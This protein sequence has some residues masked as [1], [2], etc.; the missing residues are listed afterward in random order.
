MTGMLLQAI[1]KV[2]LGVLLLAIALP[3]P[4]VSGNCRCADVKKDEGTHW[5]GNESIVMVE[6]TAFRH[7]RGRVEALGNQPVSNALVEIFDH[8]EYLLD[9]STPYRRDHS[10]QKRVAAC[11]TSAD[12][13]FCFRNLP[14]GKYELR[15][16]VDSGW[17]VTQ[18]YVAV[19]KKAGKRKGLRV[20]M[21][22]GT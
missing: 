18:I 9:R 2:A 10:E 8:P 19:D 17:E 11:H 21:Q 16:S 3:L 6:Q 1:C 15:A 7:L 5:G 4:S 20:P 13:K 12:G 22:V 14:P